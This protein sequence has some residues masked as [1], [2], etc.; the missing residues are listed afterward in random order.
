MLLIWNSFFFITQTHDVDI[1]PVQHEAGI[2]S[3]ILEKVTEE[4]VHTELQDKPDFHPPVNL[5]SKRTPPK[6]QKIDFNENSP[7]SN[8][9]FTIFFLQFRFY[10]QIFL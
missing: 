4:H 6:P 2:D 7:F 8:G 1:F 9:N 5:I 10:Y 3:G